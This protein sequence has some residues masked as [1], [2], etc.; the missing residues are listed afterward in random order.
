V[1]AVPY[2]G[3]PPRRSLAA[4]TGGRVVRLLA[5]PRVRTVE[6]RVFGGPGLRGRTSYNE[7]RLR[8]G[9]SAPFVDGP[10]MLAAV[11]VV[12]AVAESAGVLVPGAVQPV[13]PQANFAHAA[14][15]WRGLAHGISPAALRDDL[16]WSAQLCSGAPATV[17]PVWSGGAPGFAQIRLEQVGCGGRPTAAQFLTGSGDDWELLAVQAARGEVYAADL[18]PEPGGV[19]TL[20]LVGSRRMG[21]VRAG[22]F[23]VPGRVAVVPLRVAAHLHVTDNGGRVIPWP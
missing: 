21:A 8:A 7:L 20:V 18:F 22:S 6:V 11:R 2:D 14:P 13:A 1:L 3:D 19:P 23:R 4:G 17:A 10:H 9:L 5:G 15:N 12:T 16:V